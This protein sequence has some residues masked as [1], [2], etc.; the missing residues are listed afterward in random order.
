LLARGKHNKSA[1]EDELL[2]LRHQRSLQDGKS[3]P[4]L[5]VLQLIDLFLDAIK[6]EKTGYTYSDYSRWLHEFALAHG[7][8]KAR[9]ITKLM[10]LQFKN[11][12]ATREYKP[13]KIYKPK[14]VNH[15]LIGLRRCWNWA[16]DNDLV[17][18]PS[19][20][21]KLELLYAEGRQRL[22]TPEEFQALLRHAS[23]VHFKHVLLA[24]RYTPARPGDLRSLTY[25]MI[26]WDRHLW[27]IPRHKSSRT[28]KKPKP[29]II[30]VPPVVEA[31]LRYRLRRF[32]R[33]ERVFTNRRGRPWK[34]DGLVLRMRR[35][36]ERAGIQPD[37]KGEHLV[38]HTNRHTY[39]TEAARNGATGPQLQLLGG[40]TSLDMADRYVH[41]AEKD[42][43]EAGLKAVEALRNSHKSRK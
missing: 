3:Y 36:R 28:A 7:H 38:M 30:P 35:V 16:I 6:A 18:P 9:D 4:D 5:T 43:Y 21:A 1:A 15:A 2:R 34:R 19:P 33:T 31:M 37:E 39:L 22:A 12:W 41:L 14:T 8:R 26:D 11:T 40:W 25:K 23:D 29:R 13:G 17:P 27:I 24:M 42:T 10:V 32:G 20:F